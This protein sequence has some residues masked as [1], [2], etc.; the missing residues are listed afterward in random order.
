[1]L[2]VEPFQ[3][4]SPAALVHPH[5]RELAARA[6]FPG[7]H[8][9]GALE[10]WQPGDLTLLAVASAALSGDLRGRLAYRRA[11]MPLPRVLMEAKHELTMR[12]HSDAVVR[13]WRDAGAWPPAPW[14]LQMADAILALA[15]LAMT[16]RFFCGSLAERCAETLGTWGAAWWLFA[17]RLRRA[18]AAMPREAG[19]VVSA[20]GTSAAA[21][22]REELPAEVA[23]PLAG[24]AIGKLRIEAALQALEK[25]SVIFSSRVDCALLLSREML[26]HG[27]DRVTRA[28]FHGHAALSLTGGHWVL[29]FHRANV[30]LQLL[31]EVGPAVSAPRVVE[32]GVYEAECSER[33]L[34]GHPTLRWLGV[35]SYAENIGDLTGQRRDS[36]EILL[37]ARTKLLPWLGTRAQLLIARTD[38]AAAAYSAGPIDLL[39]VDADHTQRGVAADLAAWAP[40]VRPGGHVVGHDYCPQF[41]GVVQAVHA[42]LPRGATLHLA[43]DMVFWWRVPWT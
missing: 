34:S 21:L 24:L 32:L 35:D 43:P 10:G 8:T 26:R 11:T 16:V 3:G 41:N 33:L 42:A 9:A 23:V 30:I 28:E 7:L 4:I 18:V 22:L 19:D 36:E 25:E 13:L 2:G 37:S 12:N 6:E 14:L 1:M 31:A 39:F 27:R 15:D 20:L 38:A 5:W 17:R 40:L 29:D